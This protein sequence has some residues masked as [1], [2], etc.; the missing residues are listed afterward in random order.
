MTRF[1][2]SVM[3]AV[4]TAMSLVVSSAR[5][6]AIVFGFVDENNT[7]SNVG[8]FIVQS[9]A[10]GRI[11]PICSGTLISPTV[12]LTAGHCTEFFTNDLA[13]R[14]FT[15][16]VSFDRSIAFGNL[17]NLR[18]TRLIPVQQVITNPNFN[19]SQADSGDLGVLLIPA[20]LTR[21]ITPATLPT[22][23]E[24]DQLAAMN[25]LKGAVFT[26]VGYGLQNRVV[27]GGVPFFQDMNPIPRM[28]AFSSFNALNGG[29][30]RLSQNEATGDGGTCFGDSGGPNFLNVD[31]VQLL[32]ATT[33]T[34]DAVCEATNV[35]YR[36]DTRS[37]RAFLGQF[38]TLP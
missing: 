30:L 14:G 21:G 16:F 36:L 4:L 31:G 23:G 22:E 9:P 7:Y 19:Q 13:P 20:R 3:L 34:G 26:A 18:D 25:G 37:A 8:A 6:R 32:A 35:T 24:L 15:A 12:F 38:I 27:G 1:R 33:V 2:T 11:F 28:F 5:L 29:Y 10:T 17:T